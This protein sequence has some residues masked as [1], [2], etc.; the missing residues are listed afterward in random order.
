MHCLL[1]HLGF[2]P[3]QSADCRLAELRYRGRLLDTAS[4][5]WMHNFFGKLTQN[6]CNGKYNFHWYCIQWWKWFILA[7]LLFKGGSW[8]RPEN[9][10]LFDIQALERGCMVVVVWHSQDWPQPCATDINA[11]WKFFNC[12]NKLPFQSE[13]PFLKKMSVSKMG[14][15]WIL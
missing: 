4:L 11:L 14:R 10:I 7:L 2:A 1:E 8:D 3:S 13:P 9:F 6:K 12:W 5:Y 15:V